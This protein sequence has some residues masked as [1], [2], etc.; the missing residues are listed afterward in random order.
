MPSLH[1]DEATAG[2]PAWLVLVYRVPS[3]PSSNR[4]SIWRDLK[5]AGA[6]YLHQ[7]VCVLPD[8]PEPR[9]AIT[10][11]R[12]RV[13]ALGGSS[14]LFPTA[15]LPVEDEAALIAGFRDLSAQQYAEIVEECE[16]KFVKEIEF[17]HFRRNYTFAEAEEIEQ[18]LEKIRRWFAR[19]QTRDWF[20][21]PGR[22]EV[23]G[24]LDRCAAL[25][26][27]FFATVHARAGEGAER[28]DL[29]ARLTPGALEQPPPR[30]Y[31]P[32]RRRPPRARPGA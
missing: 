12:E 7:C 21:A 2:A 4:V 29:P 18:D 13:T 5:R 6:L 10:A 19:V 26:D 23:A 25:L 27:D 8:L 16:T 9:A 15:A 30:P 3:E 11:V 14:N 32:H 20:A 31:P 1:P 22:A 24:W 17:E 28:P